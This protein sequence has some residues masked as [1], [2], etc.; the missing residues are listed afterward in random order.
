M[1]MHRIEVDDEIFHYLKG[2]AEP[3]VDTPN[4]VLRK[5]LLGDKSGSIRI[6][7]VRNNGLDLPIMPTGMPIA[8]RQILEVVHIVRKEGLSRQEAT[9]NVANKYRVAPPTVIDKY[10][11]QLNLTAHAFDR[12]LTQPGLADLRALLNKKFNEHHA[13]IK[14]YLAE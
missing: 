6:S 4:T 7:V 10:C 11:R 14:R 9:H 8:L 3:F 1:R 2:K 13:M 5:E 12:L